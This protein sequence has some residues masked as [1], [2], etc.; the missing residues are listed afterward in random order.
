MS[1]IWDMDQP[2]KDWVADCIENLGKL[3]GD[4][5]PPTMDI[6]VCG[7]KFEFRLKPEELGGER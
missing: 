1:G 2:A 3:M 7:V 5:E 6:E 4:G